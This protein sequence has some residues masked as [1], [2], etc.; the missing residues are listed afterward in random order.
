MKYNHPKKDLFLCIIFFF[1]SMLTACKQK[2]EGIAIGVIMPQTGVLSEPGKKILEGIEL[3]TQ[4]YN[5]SCGNPRHKIILI[6]E[7]SKSNSKDGVSALNKLIYQD[8][9]KIVIGDLSSDAFL[10][11]APIAERNKIVM[12]SPGASNP[13]VKNAGDYIFRDYLSD[14]FDGTVM[15]NYIFKKMGGGKVAL[16]YVNSDYGIGVINAFEKEYSKL[17]GSIGY[18]NSFLPGTIDFK[19]MAIKIKET[20]PDIIY[21]VGNPTENG[22]LVKQLHSYKI[23]APIAGNLAFENDDFVTVAKGTFDSIIYSTAAFDL[24]DDSPIMKFFSKSYKTRYGKM[25]DM[26]AGLGYDVVNILIK[27]LIESD[28]NTG[29]VK[30]KL[31]KIKDFPGVTGNT[32]F[33]AYGDVMKDVYIKKM[34]GDGVSSLIESY[35]FTN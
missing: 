8:K 16:I 6:V 1:V 10:A 26:A 32:S 11:G 31:Y 4:N 21:L 22:Y 20:N 3:A 33:D 25:P 23:A 27:C 30:N 35:R 29:M 13:A 15:A 5:N 7:D 9:V 19:S 34:T 17:G 24:E 18:K 2:S 28:F 14:E 12:I